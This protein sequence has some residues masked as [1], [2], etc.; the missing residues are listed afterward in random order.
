MQT[1]KTINDIKEKISDFVPVMDGLS[2][3][4]NPFELRYFVIGKHDDRVQ[5]YKQAVIEMEAKYK[6]I[7]EALHTKATRAI[8]R[9]E[10]MLK[11]IENPQNRQDELTNARLELDL[12]KLDRENRD[13]DIGM[14]GAFKEVMDFITIIENEYSD[15]IDKTEEELLSQEVEYWKSRFAKQIHI[16]LMTTG[17][18]GA[19]NL[20]VLQSMPKELQE[21]TL[22]KS[23][24]RTEEFKKLEAKVER[25]TLTLLSESYPHKT[26]FIA[27]PDF[28]PLKLRKD[29]PEGYPEDRIVNIDRAE[30]MIASMH[31]PDE[32]EWLSRHFYIPSGKNNIVHEVI[33]PNGDMIG[34][35][36]NR[37][38]KSALS[39]GCTHI[40]FVDDDLLVDEGTLQKLYAHNLDVVGGWYVKKTPVPES[41][42]L[43]SDG[44]GSMHGVPLDCTGLIEVDWS[45][46]AGLTLVKTEV[47]KKIPYP[48]YLTT[49]QGTEDTY[50]C[51]RLREVG[52]KAYLDTS[53]KAV[54]VDKTTRMGYGFEGIKPM[55]E[56]KQLYGIKQ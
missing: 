44:T 22:A 19:G 25:E 50:F 34:E 11:M 47:F 7:Q 1:K 31:R 28:V 30:I 10:I 3:A 9:E 4:R 32:K 23:M 5:Q 2:R 21:H 52:L 42:T 51:A 56:Y 49:Q 36:R 14:T 8:D 55:D 29:A 27:P 6:A 12:N 53:I 18:I 37:I 17:R 39:L 15:L 16:D 38:V 46:A 35:W 13:T 43:V 24:V 45:L 48:W 54:H 20:T 26:E 33:C 41:A 40:F